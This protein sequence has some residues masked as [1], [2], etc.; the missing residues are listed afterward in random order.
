MAAK[1][2]PARKKAAKPVKARARA[3]TA[4]GSA[5]HRRKL[6]AE[7]YLTNGENASKAAVAAGF[8]PKTAGAAG[9]RLLK[10]VEVLTI[11]EQR[12]AELTQKYEITTDTVIRSLAQAVHFDPRKLY[13]ADGSLKDVTELDDDTAMALTGMEVSEECGPD[14]V[15]VKLEPQPH[16]GGLKRS[17]ARTVL[18]ARTKKLKWL[19]KNQAREQAM[20]HLGLFK[21]DNEQSRPMLVVKDY[22]G[23]KPE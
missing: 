21:R 16:G 11:I 13:R 5:A 22:T 19:D 10:H 9:A 18:I 6:F 23:R 4:L 7:T 12:R 3:S 15:D 14:P 1:K 2:A 17:T 20:K 8:S